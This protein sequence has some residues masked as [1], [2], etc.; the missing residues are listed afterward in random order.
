[1]GVL[2]LGFCLIGGFGN[3]CPDFI[4]VG[5]LG[6]FGG[7]WRAF[8]AQ[9]KTDQIEQADGQGSKVKA[10]PNEDDGGNRDEKGQGDP[11]Q[12]CQFFK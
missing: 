11:Q 1:M 4:N 8:D 6:R 10:G 2:A 12:S 5:R 7:R 3:R 9:N